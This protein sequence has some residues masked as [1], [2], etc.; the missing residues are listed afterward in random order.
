[1]SN[2]SDVAKESNVSRSTVSRVINNDPRISRA[3][4]QKV[5]AA[6]QK[7]QYTPIAPETDGRRRSAPMM[8]K[9]LHNIALIF[10][11]HRPVAFSTGLSARLIS[12]I[13]VAARDIGAMLF[14]S[15]LPEPKKLPQVA[16]VEESDGLILRAPHDM[17]LSWMAPELKTRPLVWIFP[18]PIGT[19]F[20]DCVLPD[21]ASVAGLAVEYL[22]GKGC[23]RPLI[24]NT[25]PEHEQYQDRA[26]H[27]KQ[28][29]PESELLEFDAQ[30]WNPSW[31]QRLSKKCSEAKGP[32]GIFFT[33]NELG[34]ARAFHTIG[35]PLSIPL[36][37][38]GHF[39]HMVASLHPNLA[40]IDVQPELLGK[41]AVDLL[42]WRIE[43][44]AEPLRTM[45]IGPC[46]VKQS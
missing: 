45:S 33:D 44:P 28:L 34:V 29:W 25:I 38:C 30:Q 27:F 43:N 39:N 16:S 19:L 32:D 13:N 23:K 7:L 12:G 1:M 14:I 35:T 17:S 26:R 24:L 37:C 31:M 22:R 4:V 18:R 11:D 42:N 21:N 3:T 5:L 10:P 6:M 41:T 8:L 40:S 9:R 20:G 46:L 2:L 36:I 15:G